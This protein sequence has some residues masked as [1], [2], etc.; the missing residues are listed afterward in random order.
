M[1]MVMILIAL[2][3]K[4]PLQLLLNYEEKKK[5]TV[6]YRYPEKGPTNIYSV[7]VPR[8]I[9]VVNLAPPRKIEALVDNAIAG[10]RQFPNVFFAIRI[11][12]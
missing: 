6:T 1:I 8:D 5:T 2:N 7:G 3:L 10:E 9:K 11:D 12:C 4:Y